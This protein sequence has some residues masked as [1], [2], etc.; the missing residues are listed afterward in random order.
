MK[1]IILAAGVGR[2]FHPF[3]Y[4][5]PKPMF[6]VC[7]KPILAWIVE[8]LREVDVN[9]IAIVVGHRAGRVKGY[10][11]D[12]SRFGCRIEY[13]HQ[14][15]PRGT[16][17][18]LLRARDWA[19]DDDFLAIY[20]DVL[21]DR[22]V[23]ERVLERFK[24][25]HPQ[26]VAAIRRVPDISRH[27]EVSVNGDGRL[28]DYTWKPRG[29]RPGMALA[30]IFAFHPT[31]FG[32]VACVPDIVEGVQNGVFPP[33]EADLAGLIPLLARSGHPLDSVEVEGDWIDIDLPWQPWDAHRMAS[34]WMER[35][36]K[37]ERT[38]EEGASIEDGAR[39]SGGV[40]LGPGA[41]VRA[42]AHIEGPAWIGA[43]T[44]ILEGAHIH[45]Y[46]VIGDNCTIGPYCEV[47]GAVGNQTMITH[48]AEFSGIVLDRS[49]FVHYCELCGIFGERSEIGAGTM[50]G[51]LRFDDQPNRV[52]V[53][54][55][56]REA[57]SFSGVLFG[58]YS[59]TGVG[60][61]IMPGRIVG[62][63]SIVGAGVILT[64][65]AEPFTA[66]L[67]KQDQ[68]V[69]PWRQEIYDR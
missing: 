6:P 21:F 63:S 51:T 45:P 64:R 28:R 49:M 4:Y 53:E 37:S 61:I 8:R 50:V 17:D 7:N 52:V 9:E 10:F 43:G 13:I 32:R 41:I 26:S 12:G 5:R 24:R 25:G 19:R 36:L 14:S 46:T 34:R 35:D 42:G 44:R 22:G 57:E 1:A 60:A 16:A 48:C 62:P 39:V 27:V 38:L 15:D 18:A 65:N 33:E 69:T 56:L 3:S 31:I 67:A 59:R 47:Q 11:H 58:D 30:G 23:L 54:G 40:C 20:G 2:K 55:Q 29:R 68:E 66:V